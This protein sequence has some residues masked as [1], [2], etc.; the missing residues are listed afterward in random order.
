MK[1][2]TIK[3]YIGNTY[4]ALT[5]LGVAYETYDREKQSKRTYF[6]CKCNRCGS[7]DIVRADHFSRKKTWHKACHNCRVDLQREIAEK[8]YPKCEKYIRDRI[9]SIKSNANS[10]KIKM[11]LTDSQIKEIILKPCYYCGQD[12][13]YGIDRVDSN[14][15]YDL[16]NCVPCCFICN[17]IKNKYSLDTFLEKIQNIYKNLF[18]EGSTTISKESTSQVNGD[19]SGE[20]LTA[21]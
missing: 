4:G 2:E 7:I 20:L 10:R 21:A 9:G 6:R 5:V 17:R 13:S 16:E 15:D 8:K 18:I 11:N 19:G 12:C 3:K 14:K 1:E